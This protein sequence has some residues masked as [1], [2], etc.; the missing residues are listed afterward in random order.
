MLVAALLSPTGGGNAIVDPCVL[1]L[2][3][4]DLNDECLL[5]QWF[6]LLRMLSRVRGYNIFYIS[7]VKLPYVEG[8]CLEGVPC[9]GSVHQ[10]F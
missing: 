2:V 8:S 5:L 6:S 10:A 1:M 9:G 7:S 3:R 4:F